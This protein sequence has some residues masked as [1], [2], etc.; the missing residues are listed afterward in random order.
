M[1][2]KQ[3]DSMGVLVPKLFYFLQPQ[4][5]KNLDVQIKN[6]HKFKASFARILVS[7]QQGFFNA[8]LRQKNIAKKH[9]KRCK[10]Y[11]YTL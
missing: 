2:W 4:K 10:E 5:I 6:L 8:D 7:V 3:R 1:G 9:I 11:D